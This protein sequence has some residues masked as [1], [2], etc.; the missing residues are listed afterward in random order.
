MEGGGVS[1]R[2]FRQKFII[3]HLTPFSVQAGFAWHGVAFGEKLGYRSET[4]V[5]IYNLSPDPLSPFARISGISA[6]S[7]RIPFSL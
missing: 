6:D 5:K 4:S 1:S 3:Y 7:P 2:A